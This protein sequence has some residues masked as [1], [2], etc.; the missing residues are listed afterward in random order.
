[1][2]GIPAIM[3]CGAVI[4]INSIFLLTRVAF[5][6]YNVVAFSWRMEQGDSRTIAKEA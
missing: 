3:A 6:S 1:M 5:S 4:Y 2:A